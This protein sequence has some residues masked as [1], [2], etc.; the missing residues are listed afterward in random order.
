MNG[1]EPSGAPRP[2]DGFR[3]AIGLG[4][5][6]APATPSAGA[7]PRHVADRATQ[8]RIAVATL[9]VT[10]GLTLIRVSR[11]WSSPPM[12]G[13]S[14]RNPFLNAVAL[15]R[16]TARLEDVLDRCQRLEA[17][18]G[19]RRNRH[20]GD[21]PLD[22]DL[23]LAEGIVR[24]EDR[25]ALPHPG[26]PSRPFVIGPLMEVWPDAVDPRDGTP[27]RGAPTPTG[28]RAWP[29]GAPGAS[30]VAGRGPLA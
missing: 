16:C 10:P 30:R 27:Y 6:L 13:G 17:R 1:G 24:S 20:W 14:A 15:F 7:C 4:V 23:L 8:L 11:W 29:I 26:I 9:A 12:R 19:R 22:L 2:P 21:R 18:A 25:L 3:L 5:S 28:P